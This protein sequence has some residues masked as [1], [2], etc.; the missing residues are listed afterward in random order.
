MGGNS[1]SHAGQQLAAHLFSQQ[2][3]ANMQHQGQHH[4]S[5]ASLLPH[6]SQRSRENFGIKLSHRFY[7]SSILQVFTL[8]FNQGPIPDLLFCLKWLYIWQPDTISSA[9]IRPIGINP[10]DI[11]RNPSDIKERF[12]DYQHAEVAIGQREL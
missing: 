6:P 10:S 7:L 4:S 3:E 11:G 9:G 12:Y 1:E 5:S 2:Q 8:V